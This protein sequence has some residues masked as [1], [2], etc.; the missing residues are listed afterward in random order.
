MHTIIR[1]LFITQSTLQ[2]LTIRH[3]TVRAK[4]G[5]PDKQAPNAAAK[6]MHTPGEGSL[7]PPT[8]QEYIS[9]ESISPQ[10]LPGI[11][12]MDPQRKQHKISIETLSPPELIAVSDGEHD[13]HILCEYLRFNFVIVFH[14]WDF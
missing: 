6:K 4:L 8:K 11:K 14:G 10:E 5:L 1:Q 3:P 12:S 9:P 7:G 2:L 13:P